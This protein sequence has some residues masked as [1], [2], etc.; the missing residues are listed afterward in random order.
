MG[1]KLIGL[2][3]EE[4]GELSEGGLAFYEYLVYD[5]GELIDAAK[6]LKSK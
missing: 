4:R 2:K 1:K 3:V 5:V 6:L